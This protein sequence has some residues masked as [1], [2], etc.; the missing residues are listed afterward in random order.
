MYVHCICKM[1]LADWLHALRSSWIHGRRWELNRLIRTGF[2]ITRA[3]E[4][5]AVVNWATQVFICRPLTASM[6]SAWYGAGSLMVV[7]FQSP[8]FGRTSR[9]SIE[10]I[11]NYLFQILNYL[12]LSSESGYGA[13]HVSDSPP[14]YFRPSLGAV[15]VRYNAGS[16][17]RARASLTHPVVRLRTGEDGVLFYVNPRPAGPIPA[18]AFCWG[19]GGGGKPPIYL[20][21]K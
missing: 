21:N 4:Q 5:W 2:N 14:N 11:Q 9:E 19:G 6:C 15:G 7:L 18:P 12:R 8:L 20:G 17:C 10:W 3:R 13:V 1:K 16:T